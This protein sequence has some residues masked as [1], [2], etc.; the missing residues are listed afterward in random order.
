VNWWRIGLTTALAWWLAWDQSKR[1]LD[2]TIHGMAE[3]ERARYASCTATLEMHKLDCRRCRRGHGLT[4]P[5]ARSLL[6]IYYPV[7]R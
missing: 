6:G 2:A 3:G 5:Q 4:C 7:Q 1:R